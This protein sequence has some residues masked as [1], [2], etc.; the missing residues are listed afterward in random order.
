[1]YEND[2]FDQAVFGPLSA[3]RAA[4]ASARASGAPDQID[5][6]RDDLDALIAQSMLNFTSLQAADKGSR[7]TA[8]DRGYRIEL[9]NQRLAF[10][11]GAFRNLLEQDNPGIDLTF[12][13]ALASYAPD[14]DLIKKSRVPLWVLK[15]LGGTSLLIQRM[16]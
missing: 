9:G 8:F 1:M 15:P 4:K 14:P 12:D 11:M 10:D 5:R 16:W 2:V 3:P 6:Q 7:V 13:D